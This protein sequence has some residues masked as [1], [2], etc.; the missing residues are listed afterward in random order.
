MYSQDTLIFVVS[1]QQDFL[2]VLQ[3]LLILPVFL[4]EI[5]LMS[6]LSIKLKLW[7]TKMCDE[8]KI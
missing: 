8:L 3:I 5:C 2:R 7:A 6:I 1:F 4:V